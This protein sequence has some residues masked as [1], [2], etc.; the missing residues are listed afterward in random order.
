MAL[1]PEEALVV[2]AGEEVLVARIGA[3]RRRRRDREAR[4]A[5][6]RRRAVV[7]GSSAV[8]QASI[9]G[10][11]MPVD[12]HAGAEVFAGT[13]N[14]HGALRVVASRPAAETVLARIVEPRAA[15]PRSGA[16]PRSSSSSASS[17]A[18]RSRR[19]GGAAP[20][21]RAPAPP[22]VDL[23]RRPL[24]LDDLPRRRLAL[25][26]RRRDDADAP[27][28]AVERGAQRHPLQGK[29]LRRGDWSPRRGR[30]RQ[31][32]NPDHGSAARHR[33]R[34]PRRRGRR[35]ASSPMAAAVESLSSHPLGRADRGGGE[36]P[37]ARVPAAS[38]PRGRGRGGRARLRR[39]RARAVGKP[40]MFSSV[41]CRS[42]RRRATPRGRGKTVVL[43]GGDERRCAASSRC[44]TPSARRRAP[45]SPRCAGSACGTS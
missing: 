44:A 37:G 32:R 43:V 6:P 9:T 45:R 21:D 26:A 19:R 29:R 34:R 23:P 28:G 3:R 27:L 36:A 31:D 14:G 42:A 33:R 25:R 5:H 4:R 15:R 35:L 17:A 18:T 24:P 20:G 13:I 39:R 16:R 2:R 22:R 7:E 10:E 8:D 38:E 40:A 41:A 11:S 30:L 1:H 12:K